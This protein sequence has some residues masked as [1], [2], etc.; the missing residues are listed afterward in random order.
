MDQDYFVKFSE[1][2]KKAQEPFQALAELNI[3]T[4]QGLTYLRPDELTSIKKPDE[5]IEKQLS[6]ALEN[7][8]KALE[9]MQKSYAIIEKAMLACAKDVKIKTESKK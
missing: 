5:L 9:F 1:M 7:G 6:L 8:R 4:L 3:K 2:A